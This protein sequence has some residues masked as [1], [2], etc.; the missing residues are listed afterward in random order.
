M[1]DLKKSP[2]QSFAPRTQQRR[3]S[4][5]AV[6]FEDS[7]HEEPNVDSKSAKHLR[8]QDSFGSNVEEMAINEILPIGSPTNRPRSPNRFSDPVRVA[9]D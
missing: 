2:G 4:L 7:G 9:S 3:S 6:L 1:T 5:P 8:R